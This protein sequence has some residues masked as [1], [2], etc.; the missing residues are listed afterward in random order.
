MAPEM[1]YQMRTPPPNTPKESSEPVA[2]STIEMGLSQSPGGVAHLAR[3]DQGAPALGQERR[4]T[5][6]WERG[7]VYRIE[8][9]SSNDLNAICA[10][11]YPITRNELTPTHIN[12][13]KMSHQMPA[14]PPNTPTESSE[15]VTTSKIHEIGASTSILSEQL[16]IRTKTGP[17]QPPGGV[18]QLDPD[19]YNTFLNNIK[20]YMDQVIDIPSVIN[21]ISELFAGHP[22]LIRGFSTFLPQG[23]GASNDPNTICATDCPVANNALTLTQTTQDASINGAAPPQPDATKG[24]ETFDL[25]TIMGLWST[26]L[27]LPQMLAILIQ[28]P[29]LTRQKIELFPPIVVRLLQPGDMPNVYA[30]ATLL[31]NGIDVTDQLG[32]ELIQSPIDGTFRFPGLSVH[33][34]GVYCLRICLYQIDFDSCPE[35]VA[36]VGYF[37]NL[38][39]H[40]GSSVIIMEKSEYPKYMVFIP[41]FDFMMETTNLEHGLYNF[42]DGLFRD[43]DGVWFDDGKIERAESLYESVWL[44]EDGEM[45]RKRTDV[46]ERNQRPPPIIPYNRNNGLVP[47]LG[48]SCSITSFVT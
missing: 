18:E 42:G 5:L 36:Q 27:P 34:Q 7:H 4:V 3:P 29:E 48:N 43:E 40:A 19:I 1:A 14:T 45:Y 15:P 23:Y 17:S 31:S 2:T 32:G 24:T 20:N 6:S 44:G 11:S 30:I 39:I 41:V 21:R 8:C 13:P 22:S 25:S 46:G 12:L 38:S 10:T 26:S 33:G 35:G 16:G 37:P 9:D 28:P 47:T